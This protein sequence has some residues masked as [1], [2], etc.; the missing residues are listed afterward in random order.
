MASSQENLGY[1]PDNAPQW[2]KL[3]DEL[4]PY[5]KKKSIFLSHFM[6]FVSIAQDDSHIYSINFDSLSYS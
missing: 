4:E 1:D 6:E 3:H 2:E 5:L